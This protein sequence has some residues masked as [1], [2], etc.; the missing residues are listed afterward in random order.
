MIGLRAG[1]KLTAAIDAWAKANGV[2]SRSEAMRALI[3]RGL[4]GGRKIPVFRAS[5]DDEEE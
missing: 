5:D 3:E 2:D 4:A 1:K